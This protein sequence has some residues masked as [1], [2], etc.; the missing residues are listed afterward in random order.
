MQSIVFLDVVGSIKGKSRPAS[1]T[2]EIAGPSTKHKPTPKERDRSFY[3]GT[4]LMT[5]KCLGL[6]QNAIVLFKHLDEVKFGIG[7]DEDLR[8]KIR[9]SSAFRKAIL[10]TITKCADIMAEKSSEGADYALIIKKCTEMQK[11]AGML[12]RNP[13]DINTIANRQLGQL[14][15]NVFPFFK[16][17][18]EIRT[19]IYGLY[20][21]EQDKNKQLHKHNRSS[22][23]PLPP[24]PLAKSCI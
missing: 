8:R 17:P 9:L 12:Q 24:L 14:G 23:H 19:G 22:S 5:H 15:V 10:E 1:S 6:S 7:G 18:L 11:I 13:G 20:M 16:L 2:E 4:L 3:E 21:G